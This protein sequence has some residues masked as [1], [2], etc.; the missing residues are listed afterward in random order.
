M[1][2]VT[3]TSRSAGLDEETRMRTK[4]LLIDDQLAC[5]EDRLQ[6]FQRDVASKLDFEF[7][8]ETGCVATPEG[9][10][11]G[12]LEQ[13]IRGLHET[14]PVDLILLDVMFPGEGNTHLGVRILK[15]IRALYP[16]LPVVMYTS[17]SAQDLDLFSRCIENGANDFVSK[18]PNELESLN[19]TLDLWLRPDL[20][21]E[22][23][24][25]PLY[26]NSQAIRSLRLNIARTSV[27]S[28]RL[29]VPPPVLITGETGTGKEVIANMLWRLGPRSR[30]PFQVV[31]CVGLPDALIE[32]EL[33][34][35]TKGA[36][37]DATAEKPGLISL[38]EGG[39]LFLDEIGDLPASAQ[40]KLLRALQERE[41]RKVGATRAERVDFQLIAATNR[42][43]EETARQGR[44]RGDLYHRLA[45]GA[46]IHAPPL[47]EHPEDIPLLMDLFLRQLSVS[48][49]ERFDPRA[50]DAM[51]TRP[52]PGNV[53]ELLGFVT[54]GLLSL[55]GNDLIVAENLGR[56]TV[57]RDHA[58]AEALP[59]DGAEWCRTRVMAELCLA[60][61]AK[62]RVQKDKG[63]RWRAEFMRR[64]YPSSRRDN[65]EGV[66]DL[67]KRLTGSPWGYPDWQD[68]TEIRNL[69]T[70]LT[71]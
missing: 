7:V 6:Y 22:H 1:K 56:Q 24:A 34:G 3:L 45:A 68:D 48:G 28:Y 14:W 20:D 10:R 67:V 27:N 70:E 18:G 44:F 49:R 71:E 55:G 69:I 26:G 50:Y 23:A 32:S 51:M 36:F 25:R 53:R 57:D 30:G 31:E 61:A 58:P 43:L 9:S 15:E 39:V 47:R 11:V 35:H 37:T 29:R 52:W 13:A 2:G 46:H 12:S 63:D 33:F 41:I 60:V 59:D 64:L 42:D 21:R 19:R 16:T 5:A 8:Y 54:R 17:L 66:K 40:A 65:A 62:R 4:V 38:A